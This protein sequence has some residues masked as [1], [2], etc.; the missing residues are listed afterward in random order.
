MK[1][2]I[3]YAVTLFMAL[4]IALPAISQSVNKLSKKEKKEG[5]VLLFNGKDFNGWR[6]CNGTAM[7]ANWAIDDNA[8]KVFIGEGKQP[9]QGANGDIL[10]GNKKFKN[11]ELS[12]DWKASKAANSG[13]FYDVREVKGQPIYYAAPEVQVLDNVDASDNKVDSHLAGSLYD[14]LPA[15][16]KT[17]HPAGSWNTIVIRVKDGKVT[18]TQ[19]G[20]KVV[21]Y[22]LWTPEWDAMVAKSK[23]K[24]FPGFTEGISKEGYIGLQDHGYP[25]WFR[26]IKIREL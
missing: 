21:S 15:D 5:W 18:H 7:P 17:V 2:N 12:I 9:G 20:V 26:N 25:V 22:T 23:F 1:R 8:M 6:Q 10:F 3:F 4:L 16:P 14:I 13:I 19:N 11:F 24:D